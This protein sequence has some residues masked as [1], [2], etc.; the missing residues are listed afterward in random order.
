MFKNLAICKSVDHVLS[1]IDPDD[2]RQLARL[3][4]AYIA[5]ITVFWA[6]MAMLSFTA[7]HKDSVEELFLDAVAGVGISK[8][9]ANRH[10]VGTCLG[11]CVWTLVLGDLYSRSS[12]CCLDADSRVAD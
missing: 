11:R 10:L 3:T 9:W 8:V 12:E 2:S 1:R 6:V 4:L 7:P 5:L